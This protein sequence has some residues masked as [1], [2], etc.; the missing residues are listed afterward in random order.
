MIKKKCLFCGK[1]F[2]VVANRIKFCS[3]KCS[4]DNQRGKTIKKT[5]K[6]L[7][8]YKINRGKN[9]HSWKGGKHKDKAGYIQIW[10]PEHPRAC[11]SYIREHV[12][13]ME[14]YLGRYLIAPEEVHHINGIKDD[15][16]IEN[17]QLCKNHLE[18]SRLEKGWELI[19][20]EWWKTCS[21][22]KQFLLV[23]DNFYKRK[24]SKKRKGYF[25]QCIPCSIKTCVAWSRRN[26]CQS[27][28]RSSS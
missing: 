9:H 25:F 6:M 11:Y 20:G 18:H 26:R 27:K 5:Q 22:C 23:K 8:F 15:N 24:R 19:D 16:R 12:L 17:L 10:C 7:D 14:K 2:L 13:V 4:S 3:H 1:G 21:R 28:K